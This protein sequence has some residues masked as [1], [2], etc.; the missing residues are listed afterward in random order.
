MDEYIG[1]ATTGLSRGTEKDGEMTENREVLTYQTYVKLPE[2]L[3]LQAPRSDP[4]EHDEMLFI[5]VHQVHELWFKVVL[6]ELDHLRTLFAA[7]DAPRAAATAKRVLTVLKVLV[8][9]LDT[10]ETMTPVEFDSF[11]DRLETASGFQSAQFREI[12]F[13]MG[14]KQAKVLRWFPEGSAERA[15]LDGRMAEPTVWDA[16]LRFLKAKGCA[17]PERALSR[18]VTEAVAPDPEVQEVLV[19]VYRTDPE[20]ASLCER[21]VDMDEGVQEWRYRHVKMVERTIGTKQGTGGSTAV[22][23]LMSTV[24][25]K[26]FPDLWAIRSVL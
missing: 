12:E 10:L 21:L 20:L 26:A 3:S 11:R 1:A 5:V 4:E 25:A 9:Q 19:R 14:L 15:G 13:V 17:I 8:S 6:H 18:E 24:G 22:E 23:Y 2:L 7:G 16:F